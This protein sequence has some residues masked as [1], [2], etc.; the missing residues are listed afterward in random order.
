MSR[1][2]CPGSSFF[3]GDGEGGDGFSPVSLRAA[4]APACGYGETE[5]DDFPTASSPPSFNMRWP[6]PGGSG[7][8]DA[9][10]RPRPAPLLLLARARDLSV[11]SDLCKVLCDTGNPL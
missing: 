7:D 3:F 11:I 1:E 6:A 5:A 2:A 9:A 4:G 10:A 8:G